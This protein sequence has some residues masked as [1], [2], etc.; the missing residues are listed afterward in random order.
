MPDTETASRS[1]ASR[2]VRPSISVRRRA[3]RYGDGSMSPIVTIV[4]A[5][6]GTEVTMR[7]TVDI[8]GTGKDVAPT[9]KGKSRTYELDKGQ[10]LTFEQPADLLGS[11]IK[12]NKPVGLWGEQKCIKIDD[13]ACDS[14]H[15]QIPPVRALGSEYVG[16]RYR[17]RVDGKEERPPWRV[18]GVVDG[19]ILEWDPAPPEGAPTA[20]GVGGGVVDRLRELKLPVLAYTGSAKTIFRDRTGEY[21]F[22]NTRSAAYY[23]LRQLLEPAYGAELMLPPDDLMI[24]DLNTPRW[25]IMTQRT[26]ARRP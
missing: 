21:G 18:V 14:A 17:N 11:V 10:V 15:Q 6:D 9:P 20:I 1:A 19:T 22:S 12:A 5:E 23:N 24:S 13:W 4:A 7:P 26:L 2:M 16:A 8:A 25:T 3:S